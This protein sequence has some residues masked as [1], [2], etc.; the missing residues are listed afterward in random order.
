MQL[1]L[2]LTISPQPTISYKDIKMS[3]PSSTSPAL[4]KVLLWATPRSISTVFLKCM[5]YVPDTVAWHEPWMQVKKFG[6]DRADPTDER[7]R[8]MVE[9]LG[10]KAAVDKIEGGFDASNCTYDWIK[11]KLEGDFPGKK[12]V[13]VK[14]LAAT[15]INQTNTIPD[16]FRHT[17]LIRHPVKFAQSVFKIMAKAHA[18]GA[19]VDMGKNP[20]PKQYP[21]QDTYNVLQYIKENHNPNPIIIDADDFLANPEKVLEAY[22]KAVD[23]PYSPDLLRWEAGDDVM[24]K[25]WMVPKETIL[26]FRMIGAHDSTLEST[27][28][29]RKERQAP[30][31]ISEVPEMMRPLIEAELPYYEKLYAER[32][33]IQ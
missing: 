24:T 28:F 32:L 7:F 1:E 17:F 16:G 25:H 29:E 31:V 9:K 12:M 19:A 4:N 10:G 20:I 33:I 27:G 22:C 14:E 18:K 30:P 15:V 6:K 23:I 11:D 26:T 3:S 8:Q 13:F 5:T 21:Y 2:T